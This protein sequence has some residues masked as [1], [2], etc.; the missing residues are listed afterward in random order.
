MA[1]DE[2]RHNLFTSAGERRIAVVD[3]EGGVTTADDG[4]AAKTGASEEED[5]RVIVRSNKGSIYY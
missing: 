5:E 2:W 4:V 1:P 3:G